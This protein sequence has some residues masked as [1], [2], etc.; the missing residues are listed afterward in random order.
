MT[1]QSKP[2]ICLD[3]WVKTLV[4]GDL[5]ATVTVTSNNTLNYKRALEMFVF[6]GAQTGA[7]K[8]T[9]E[10]TAGTA[11]LT[12]AVSAVDVGAW[13]LV[14]VADRASPGSQSWTLPGTLTS[15]AQ[16]IG[17]GGGAVSGV[18]ATGQPGVTG[19]VGQYT[20]SGTVSTATAAMFAIVVEP[21]T[22]TVANSA[23]AGPDVQSEPRVP[24]SRTATATGSPTSWAW[25]ASPAL[26]LTGASTA[27]VSF[28][29]PP[30][31]A[32]VTYTLTVTATYASGPPAVDSFDVSVYPVTK[33]YFAVGGGEVP[34][35]I[36]KFT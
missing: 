16:F 21:S 10:T 1:A 24:I 13:V 31:I 35:R 6:S 28:T 12:P 26:T 25:T 15:Q 27:T 9:L 4:A 23:S 11:H 30:S 5:G 34:L 8:S 19:P 22:A 17:S 32:P 3:V 36:S 2:G 7:A 33:R 18:T 14:G 29:T 20:I